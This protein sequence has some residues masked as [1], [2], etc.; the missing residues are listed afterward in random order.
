MAVEL[1]PYQREA[2][3]TIASRLKKNPTALLQAPTGSGK[4]LAPGTPVL[5][6]DGRVAPVE[7]LKIGDRLMGPDSLPR[8]IVSLASGREEMF[9]IV[10]NKG[11]PFAVNSSHVLS[12]RIT[13]MGRGKAALGPGGERHKAGDIVNVSVADYLKGTKTFRHVAK[14]YRAGAVAFPWPERELPI[15]PYI[16]GVWLGDGTSNSSEICN[17][18]HEVLKAWRDYAVMI[19]HVC[20]LVE[21]KGRVPIHRIKHAYDRKGVNTRSHPNKSRHALFQ[22]NLTLNKHI[23]QIYKTASVNDRLELLAGIIDTDGYLS[24]G[25]YDLCLKQETLANDIAFVARSLGLAAT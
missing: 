24:R 5:L 11:A 4:C 10:P 23:P 16:L 13:G 25:C 17:V 18:D 12:L 8:E 1:R 22:L 3:E 2:V 19:N 21:C 20:S 15:P 9:Q 7:N 14:G 6:Y